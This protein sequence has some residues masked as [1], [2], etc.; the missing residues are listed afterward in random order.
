M[1]KHR[2]HI[3]I[4]LGLSFGVGLAPDF[5]HA[6]S[7]N[8]LVSLIPAIILGTVIGGILGS[9][10]LIWIRR[11][12]VDG[13]VTL[14]VGATVIIA[15]YALVIYV[16]PSSSF[17]PP[18]EFCSVLLAKDNVDCGYK[19]FLIQSVSDFTLLV[20][21]YLGGIWFEQAM[22]KRIIYRFVLR[23]ES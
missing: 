2:V 17:T 21:F 4:I 6:V 11:H 8:S 14:G 19:S 3:P 22:K 13:V 20:S 23:R 7:Y 5:L 10:C 16:I 15:L 1:V 18:S 12:A 9:G